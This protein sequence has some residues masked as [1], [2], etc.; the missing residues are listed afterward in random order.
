MK[1]K[2]IL[3][4]LDGTLINSLNDIASSVNRVLS[5]HGFPIHPTDAYRYFIGDGVI[6]LIQHAL[7]EDQ[8]N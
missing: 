7:P 4:D 3:F 5:L 8:R 6:M 2:A 1:F